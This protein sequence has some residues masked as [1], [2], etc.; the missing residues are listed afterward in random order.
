VARRLVFVRNRYLDSVLLMHAARRIVALPGI[1]DAAVLM[2]T[3]ANRRVL[4][5]MGYDA[6]LLGEARPEDIVFGV[7]GDE[8]AVEGALADAERWLSFDAGGGPSGLPARTLEEAAARRPEASVALIS[9]PG[10]HAAREA[11]RALSLGLNVFLFSSNVS[12]EDELGLKREAA[13]RGLIVMGPDCGSAIISGVGLGFANSVR[14]GPVGVVASSGT[15]LQEL[16]CLVH[17]GGSGIS[18]AIGTGGRDLSD[19]VG[20]LSTL[21][22]LEALERDTSTGV[23][24]ILGK[25]SGSRTQ[26]MLLERL[27][28][29]PK[30][31]V[32]CLLG[33]TAEALASVAGPNVRAT[34]LRFARTI[35]AAAELCLTA[36]G[37][38]S[39]PGTG[40]SGAEH[41]R[42]VE[43]AVGHMA[44]SQRY[45]RGIFAGGTF[46][47]QAQALARDAGL[48]VW[49]NAPLEG[50]RKL[51]DALSSREHS[52]VDM[53]AE[54]LVQ[55]RAHPMIDATLR[56]R[57]L[58]AELEDPGVAVLLLDFVLGAVSSP[59]PAGDLAQAIGR[60]RERAARQGRDV[61]VVASICGTEL[62]AQGLGSQRAVL[63]GAGVLVLPTAAEAARLAIGASVALGRRGQ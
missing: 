23:V 60:G 18:H 7:E 38:T 20:G 54:E 1:S 53:G 17:R 47:Y 6:E 62:D 58:E 52:L 26:A 49:S 41:E 3:E 2:G 12:V 45:L 56:R 40:R 29:C 59:D 4:A 51:P 57:R 42:L 46:C 22:A 33:A 27:G 5:G 32:V 48:A 21:S 36:A 11:R 43:L 9:V 19:S 34:G 61:L 24:T 10:E 15:G 13:S 37:L 63:E 14:R 28:R 50:M 31:V 55:G 25:P 35:D 44:P 16:C 8:A 39:S 30:P